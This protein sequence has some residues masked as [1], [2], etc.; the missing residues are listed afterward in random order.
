[1]LNAEDDIH[2]LIEGC[3]KNNRKAQELLYKKFYEAMSSLCIRYISNQ[4]DAMQVLNDG[5]LK[6]FK[7]IDSYSPYK[8]GLYTWI[9]KIII[10]TALD[11]LRKKPLL[12]SRDLSGIEEGSS[13]ENSIIQKMNADDLLNTIKQLPPAT[14]LVFNLY[15]VEGFNHREIAEMLNISE[16]TSKWHLSDARRELKQMIPLKQKKIMK[17][18][19]KNINP[20]AEK[21]EQINVPNADASWQ[22]MHTALDLHMSDKKRKRRKFFF[23]MIFLSSLATLLFFADIIY[24]KK[25]PHKKNILSDNHTAITKKKNDSKDNSSSDSAETNNKNKTQDNEILNDQKTVA[26]KKKTDNKNA[27]LKTADSVNKLDHKQSFSD[28]KF[29]N[30]K[31]KSGKNKNNSQISITSNAEESAESLNSTNKKYFANKKT[32]VHSKNKSPNSNQKD[33]DNGYVKDRIHK[34]QL[35]KSTGKNVAVKKQKNNIN[36]D[37]RKEDFVKEDGINKSD[38]QPQPQK[39]EISSS[40]IRMSKIKITDTLDDKKFA[41]NCPQKAIED[42]TNKTHKGIALALGI[43]YAYFF[44]V[45][46]QQYSNLGTNGI[47]NFLTNY[48]LI[49]MFRVYLNKKTYVQLEAEIDAPQYTKSLLVV[50]N[51]VNSVNGS[52]AVS[53]QD[54]AIIKKLFYYNLPLSIHYSFFK[55]FYIGTGLQFSLLTNGVG[56]FGSKVDSSTNGY[57]TYIHTSF[58]NGNLKNDPAFK[59]IKSNEWRFLFDVNYEWQNIVFGIRYNQALS[60]FINTPVQA[61]NSAALFY[62]RFIFWKNKSAKNYFPNNWSK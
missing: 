45:G 52:Q 51:K 32:N 40:A 31:E 16:G 55:N 13:I 1:M 7:N 30:R 27:I 36:L 39:I 17:D 48:A 59:E 3:K 41:I 12:Y 60:N 53:I 62:V 26:D 29:E 54:S 5:F 11:F 47:N 25:S 22:D 38:D 56:M 21:L 14:Q 35:L 34:A 33:N 46:K 43:D 50:N 57:S 9:R 15:T 20:W 10:N 28:K 18:Q 6:V 44:P 24:F 23:W 2:E 37:S 49:P 42:K 58:Q 19:I 4:Q 61:K 8:A